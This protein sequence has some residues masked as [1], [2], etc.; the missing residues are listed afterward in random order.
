MLN[1]IKRRF[2]M[3]RLAHLERRYRAIQPG[4]LS[5][6]HTVGEIP[7]PETRWANGY[8]TIT[9]SEWCFTLGLFQGLFH[10][11]RPEGAMKMLDIGCGI[12]RLYLA[13]KPQMGASDTY[14]GLDVM[15]DAIDVCRKAYGDDPRT[16]FVHLPVHNATYASD[17]GAERTA[18]PFD[19]SSFNFASALSVWTHFSEDDFFFY[20]K[21]LGRVLEPGGK[22]MITFFIMDE[23]YDATLAGRTSA[24]SAYY[25]QPEEMWKYDVPAY[26]SD[27]FF[28]IK[29]AKVPED[30]IGVR[31]SAFDRAV[32]EAGLSIAEYIPGYWKE[33]PGYWFQDVVVFEKA[34]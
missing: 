21:E 23:H 19:D 24:T 8:G 5:R 30:A 12:G 29:A 31:K 14:T 25:P 32:A 9:Y 18:W 4:Y 28:T 10:R 20:L 33:R 17:A 11:L 15:P 34:G 6:V 3:K 2:D 13:M 16:S 7:D 1:R 22:A 27:E 26:G